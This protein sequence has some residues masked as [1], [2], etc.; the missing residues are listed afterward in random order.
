MVKATGDLRQEVKKV[1]VITPRFDAESI[2]ADK[3]SSGLYSMLEHGAD[4]AA[5]N[6]DQAHH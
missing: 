3:T 4:L 1:A 6:P 5:D 2:P